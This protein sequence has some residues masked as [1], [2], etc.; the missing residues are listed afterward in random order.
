MACQSDPE[1]QRTKKTV[2]ERISHMFDNPFMSDIQFTCG[3]SK[4]KCFYAHKYVLATSS[5]VFHVMFYGDLAEKNSVID[6]ADIDEESFE[7]FLRFLYTDKFTEKI[8]IAV[9]VKYLAKKYDIPCLEE[10][11][12]KL[13]KSGLKT[14]NV[15]MVLEQAML[16]DQEKLK[17]R[18]WEMVDRKT[19]A[20]VSSAA[21]SNISQK[22]LIEILKRN[23]LNIEEIELFQAVLKWSNQQ[24]S[25]KELETTDENRREVLGDALCQ[26]RFNSMPQKTFSKTFSSSALLT[27]VEKVSIYEIFNDVE[28]LDSP[29][30]NVTKRHYYQSCSLFNVQCPDDL[31]KPSKISRKA[32]R[33]Q[34]LNLTFSKP[35]FIH[36]V[37]LFG[38]DN[39]LDQY[40]VQLR[41]GREESVFGFVNSTKDRQGISGFD[42]MLRQ[43]VR[44]N[45]K[46]KVSIQAD[47]KGPKSFRGQNPRKSTKVDGVTVTFHATHVP[48]ASGKIEKSNQ[49]YK[50]IFTR[51][52]TE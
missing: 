16:F 25:K 45:P 7:A 38:V 10:E 33:H 3:E 11:C 36:G 51:S 23:S 26:I 50:I 28:N 8:K 30:W 1:W 21:F 31:I 18:C 20:A 12:D 40:E 52:I 24:C 14:E 27:V 15:V 9:G 6:L 35:V 46:E 39:G 32:L 43:P 29:Q 41:V 5:P 47:I 48:N 34:R 44:V 22:T 13:I 19:S 17:N 4:R 2:L 49:F 37:R 42:V